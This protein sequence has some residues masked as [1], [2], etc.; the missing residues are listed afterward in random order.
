MSA[1]ELLLLLTSTAAAA[2]EE[3]TH[4]LHLLLLLDQLLMP[5]CYTLS[6]ILA[7]AIATALIVTAFCM[8]RE[9]NIVIVV[10]DSVSTTTTDDS[11]SSRRTIRV[12]YEE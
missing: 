12:V 6:L 4:P 1:H 8:Y 10:S 5:I 9:P 2:E 7:Y 3:S 11:N